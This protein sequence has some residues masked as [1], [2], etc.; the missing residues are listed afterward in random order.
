MSWSCFN[1]FQIGASNCTSN[2]QRRSITVLCR[3]AI[4]FRWQRV[5]HPWLARGDARGLD[6]LYV[7]AWP[8]SIQLLIFSG[9]QRNTTT[10]RLSLFRF[11]LS[12]FLLSLHVLD[13]FRSPHSLCSFYALYHRRWYSSSSPTSPLQPLLRTTL[14]PPSILYKTPVWILPATLYIQSQFQHVNLPTSAPSI[15]APHHV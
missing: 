9:V 2:R 12:P 5:G 11:F 15:L 7:M 1:S 6:S 14:S 10:P 13:T 3:E 8:A 4:F